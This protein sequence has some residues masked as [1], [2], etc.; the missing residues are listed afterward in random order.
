M[1]NVIFERLDHLLVGF[2]VQILHRCLR[3]LELILDAVKKPKRGINCRLH[4][5]Q[6][7]AQLQLRLQIGHRR[8][9]VRIETYLNPLF[10]FL[11]AQRQPDEVSARQYLWSARR[12][13]KSRLFLGGG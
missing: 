13:A 5:P 3:V 6:L 1:L 11:L 9:H 4:I 7:E 10:K 8:I 12:A 2:L